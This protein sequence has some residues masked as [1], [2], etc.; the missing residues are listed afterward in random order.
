MVTVDPASA[1]PI[2]LG[3]L[4]FAGDAGVVDDTIGAAGAV[5]STVNDWLN[6]L[7]VGLDD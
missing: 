3:A 6:E 5:W 4:L 7:L 2:T 1:D